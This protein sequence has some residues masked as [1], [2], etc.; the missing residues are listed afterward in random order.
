[1]PKLPVTNL[2]QGARGRAVMQW[3]VGLPASSQVC[4]QTAWH[5]GKTM[6]PNNQQVYRKCSS[7]QASAQRRLNPHL[8]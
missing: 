4:R 5:G 7:V 8:M 2:R 6:P 3:H 1:M